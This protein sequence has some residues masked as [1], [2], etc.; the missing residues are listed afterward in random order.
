MV[1][2]LFTVIKLIESHF[3]YDFTLQIRSHKIRYKGASSWLKI[4]PFGFRKMLGWL[5]QKYGKPIVVTENGFSDF[6]G[7]L[8]DEQRI[9]YYKHYINQ[10]LKAVK[11]DKVDVEGY[12]ACKH[13]LKVIIKKILIVHILM[14]FTHLHF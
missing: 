2:Y 11:I 5:S 3:V 10:M 14:F 6:L 7:N 8:D 4:T 12:F 13:F 9:Y 1:S